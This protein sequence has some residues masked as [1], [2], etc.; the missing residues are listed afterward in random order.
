MDIE[1][2]EKMRRYFNTEGRCKP[3]IHYMVR[4][5]DRLDKIKRLYIDQGKYFIINRGRQ[6]GKTTTLMA[7][8]EYLKDDYTVLPMD[9]QLMSSANFSDESAFV[10]SFIEY[11][12]DLVS[13][14]K[15]LTE[16]I[17]LAV[18][19][20]L[21]ALKDSQRIHMDRL[22]R[23][24]SRLCKTAK[25]PVVLMIDEVDSASNHQ[26]FLDFLAMLRGYYLNQDYSSTF[27]SVILAG[28]YD[29]KNLKL[30][31]RPEEKH[32]YN[33]PWNIAADFDINMSLSASKIAAMLDEYETDLGT[34]MD[35][36]TVAEEIY[37]Y[38]SGY[39]YLVSAICKIL[40]EK[41]P[42]SERFLVNSPWTR[43]GI[44]EAVK[45]ILRSRL[46]LFDSMV[47]QLDIFVDLRGMIQS[48]LYQGE[49]IVF[50]PDRKSISIGIM[51]GFLREKIGQIEIANRI[52]EMRLLNMLL[53]DESVKSE[54]FFYGQN[55]MNQFIT[56]GKLNMDLVLEKF[57]I[58]FTDIYGHNDE[59]FV[60]A[61]GRKFFLLYLKP[62][63]N[64]VGNYY[65]EAQ[66]R[67]SKRTDVIIDYLGQQFIVELK[68]W[69]GNEYHERGEEQLREYLD[70]YH[71]EKG[72]LLSFNFNKKKKP[73]MREVRIDGKMI[74]EA[75]V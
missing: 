33:S 25:K 61:H 6:Y 72:Y 3:D 13:E 75:V 37:Q 23:G 68:I 28:V 36:E 70:Y 34:G 63:I 38:T 19:E 62:I 73:G 71:L 29:I 64:G 26:V 10:I 67:D 20:N 55:N 41:L 5:D 54:M 32:Q 53:S 21:A 15:E 49:K 57:V 22:F 9:F 51:F 18:F 35:T 39:P 52:F 11:L 1:G 43:E 17:D 69:H 31:L 45:I 7:L 46:P 4:L 44:R 74:V 24:L 12:E 56:G 65:I 66:T 2:R 47:K 59:R 14:R 40:D 30:K 27:R 16:N 50:N 60:E 42:E 48:I 8:A 58:Y